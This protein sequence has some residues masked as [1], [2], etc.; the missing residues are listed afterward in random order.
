MLRLCRDCRGADSDTRAACL[1]EH[2][3]GRRYQRH[4]RWFCWLGERRCAD[5]ERQASVT[6]NAKLTAI[7]LNSLDDKLDK[8][9]ALL[10]E[11]ELC[12]VGPALREALVGRREAKVVVHIDPDE[13]PLP[14]NPP[15][16][17]AEPTFA[18]GL[19]H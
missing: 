4:A 16:S 7:L 14:F 6:A 5:I 11:A 1:S 18:N 17:Q 15:P 12:R 3:D 8:A 2:R 10:N 19:V 13:P 9:I